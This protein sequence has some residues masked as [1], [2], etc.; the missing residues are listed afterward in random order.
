[1]IS[2]H[3]VLFFYSIKISSI[4][5]TLS[6]LSTA[7]LMTSFLEPF[8]Y[9]R[10]FRI[11]ELFFGLIAIVGLSLIFGVQIEN[12]YAILVSLICTLLS[13]LFSI[14][15]GYLIKEYSSFQI[16]FYEIIFG[17]FVIS[18]VIIFSDIKLPTLRSI[19]LSNWIYIFILGSLCT[20]YAFV[21]S[22]HI[23]K[24]ITPYTMMMSLNL[25]PVYG[26][27]FSLIIF[28]EKEHMD[29]QFYIGAGIILLGVIGNI[30][31]K[32]KKLS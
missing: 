12:N 1:M 16:S 18:I 31:F 32:Y 30:F 5:L 23:L 24:Y 21:A 6:I 19:K 11:H 14:L 20:A 2:F 26:I 29:I 27:I 4:S 25:E 15:N 9:N 3:W 28:G 17:L 22:T 7:S 13:V 8:F 10:P